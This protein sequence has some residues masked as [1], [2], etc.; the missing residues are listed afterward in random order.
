MLPIQQFTRSSIGEFE[1][2]ISGTWPEE[3]SGYIFIAAP[4][5]KAGE[6]HLFGGTGVII[7]WD[8]TPT[9]GSVKVDCQPLKTWDSFWQNILPITWEQIAFFPAKMSLFGIAEPANTGVVNMDGRLIFTADAGRYWEVDPV[10]LETITP[11]G[12]FDEHIISVPLS[13]FPMVTNTAHPLYDPENKLLIT[14]EL[15]SVPRS[16]EMFTDMVS[17]VYITLWD[18]K[19]ILKHWQL[20]GTTLD[21]SPHTA[22]V[23]EECVMIPDMPFQMGLTTLMGLN[24]PPA[25]A[26]PQTQIYIV[27]RKYLKE[28]NYTVPSRLV[29]FP[30]DSY[31]FLCNYR[32][33]DG[34]I[35]MVA[36]QQATISLT[37]A[38]EPNDVNHFTGER[39]SKEVWGMPWMF[40]FDPGVV[41]KVVIR[42]AKL[43]SEQAFIHPGW[44]S[45]ML[46]ASDPREQFTPTGYSTIYQGYAGFYPELICRRHY[47]EFRDHPNRLVSDEQLPK[48][49]LPS[50]IAAIPTGLNWDELTEKIKAEYEENPDYDLPHLGSD[51]LD[52]YVYPDGYI[53]DSIQFIPQGKGYIMTTVFADKLSEAWLFAAD[54]LRNGPIA[55]LSLPEEVC[56]G[57]TLHSEYFDKIAPAPRQYRVNHLECALRSLVAVPF[58]FFSGRK[59]KVLNR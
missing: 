4:Y 27:E 40:A 57:F 50:V 29:T 26:Y 52:F 25:K 47:L 1:A 37:E 51:L 6:R 53:Q 42:D 36:V 48:Y 23:S 30:G 32:H 11:V 5:H 8:L 46:Y 43:I 41:R 21:G 7:R 22:I 31:H 56:F 15:K 28:E 10:T 14:C 49:N 35:H 58:E 24:I 2:K 19:S 59:D 33:Q 54:N 39:F 3:I 34:N 45:T 13:L 38:L 44:Y 12:Y 55:K 18:G 16:G 9:N 17:G 20:D